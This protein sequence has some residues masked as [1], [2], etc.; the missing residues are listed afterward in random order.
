M[1][2]Q[3]FA[4]IRHMLLKVY[5]PYGFVDLNF[6]SELLHELQAVRMILYPEQN[7]QT[8]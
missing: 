2:I 4:V 5:F 8:C 7:R 1:G 6:F 3:L